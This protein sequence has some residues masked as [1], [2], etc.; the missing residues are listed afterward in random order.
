MQETLLVCSK[1]TRKYLPKY[2][3]IHLVTSAPKKSLLKFLGTYNNVLYITSQIDDA[4]GIKR[5]KTG[6]AQTLKQFSDD[7]KKGVNKLLK[8]GI[9]KGYIPAINPK[10]NLP[11]NSYGRYLDYM[12]ANLTH[13]LRA[14]FGN[15]INFSPE[16]PGG[17][18]KLVDETDAK[19]FFKFTNTKN[20]NI[21]FKYFY[22][23]V[24]YNRIS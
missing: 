22:K 1:T 24:N 13:P 18:L 19:K 17:I 4:L 12:R 15:L 5:P 11:I 10:N 3:N 8:I 7:Y 16:H 20:K 6:Q 21:C 23:S 9:K 14:V 2:S